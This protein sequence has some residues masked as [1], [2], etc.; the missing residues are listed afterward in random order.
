MEPFTALQ[1]ACEGITFERRR[2]YCAS[3]PHSGLACIQPLFPT[4]QNC[5]TNCTCA[6]DCDARTDAKGSLN[7]RGDLDCTP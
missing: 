4:V 2:C 1:G 6:A 5:F 7:A 3:A